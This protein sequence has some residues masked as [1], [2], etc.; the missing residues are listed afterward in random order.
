VFLVGYCGAHGLLEAYQVQ[1]DTDGEPPRTFHSTCLELAADKVHFFG[2][3]V[4]DAQDHLDALR[5]EGEVQMGRTVAPIHV[6]RAF[7]D[8]PEYPSIGGDVQIGF[9]VG[10]RFVRGAT[11]RPAIPGDPTAGTVMRI[12]NIDIQKLGP[13]GPCAI[14]I[15]GLHGF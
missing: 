8:N 15:T 3:H 9:T 11:Y 6:I 5:V 13:V 14:G 2:A 10:T 4:D 7:I 1:L 12:N